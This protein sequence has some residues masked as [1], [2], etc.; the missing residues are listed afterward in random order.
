MGVFSWGPC[1]LGIDRSLSQ[2]R[3]LW[4]GVAKIALSHLPVNTGPYI[5]STSKLP[6]A[7]TIISAICKIM[8]MMYCISEYFVLG[9]LCFMVLYLTSGSGLTVVPIGPD[10]RVLLV[11]PEEGSDC[12]LEH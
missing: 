3:V 9:L 12:G 4:A 10:W 6:K 8:I 7:V 1:N 2:T 11:Q 5:Q